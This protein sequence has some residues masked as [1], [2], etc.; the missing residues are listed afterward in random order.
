MSFSSETYSGILLVV[1]H[2]QRVNYLL[3]IKAHLHQ[4]HHRLHKIQSK[5]HRLFTSS[6]QHV[7]LALSSLP[8]QNSMLLHR[9]LF[10]SLTAKNVFLVF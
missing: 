2:S 5:I 9:D 4:C 6:L 7:T 8:S 3:L 1:V 10:K